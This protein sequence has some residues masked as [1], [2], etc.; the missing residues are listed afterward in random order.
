VRETLRAG[1][2]VRRSRNESSFPRIE[3]P[4]LGAEQWWHERRS[5]STGPR[6]YGT[7]LDGVD[8]VYLV[9]P[10]MR[11]RFADQVAAFLDAAADAG[12]RHVTLL[13]AHG[14]GDVQDREG[15][16]GLPGRQEQRGHTALESGDALLDHVGGR[17]HDAGVD[18]ARL[19]Q[20]EQRGG[21]VGVA[22]RVRRRLVDRQRPG[23]GGAIGAL[24]YVDLL[25]L[26]A[27]GVR[28]VFEFGCHY[29]F[30]PGGRQP[31]SEGQQVFSEESMFVFSTSQSSP[32]QLRHEAIDDLNDVF[33]GQSHTWCR[34][35]ESITTDLRHEVFEPIGNR[36]G[37]SDQCVFLRE[38]CSGEFP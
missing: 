26:E 3:T 18:V 32:L 2:Q 4:S 11:V 1:K 17:V 28:A 20:P 5:S 7:A 10:T 36:C 8:R 12:V 22:E 34:D 38:V 24:T 30:F 31:F 16:G 14:A 9:P 37:G 27:P 25:R 29:Y 19:G 21:V 13:S 6:T 35:E 33:P 23:I 15:R